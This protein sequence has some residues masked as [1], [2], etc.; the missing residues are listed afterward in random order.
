MSESTFRVYGRSDDLIEVEGPLFSDEFGAYDKTRE[1]HLSDGSIL[2]VGYGKMVGGVEEGIWS[3]KLVK[4]GSAFIR[5]EECF[6]ADAKIYSDIAYF[7]PTVSAACIHKSLPEGTTKE[8][9]CP[10]CSHAFTVVAC[11]ACG[12]DIGE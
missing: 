9:V 3:V 11:K 1:V 6:D 8:I 10:E 4:Q 2:S 7:E 5:I 12:M